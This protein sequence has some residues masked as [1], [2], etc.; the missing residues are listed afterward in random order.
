MSVLVRVP[1]DF[2][3]V[4]LPEEL[5]IPLAVATDLI[6]PS[7]GSS[8]GPNTSGPSL[9]SS[10]PSDSGAPGSQ[11]T[12]ISVPENSVKSTSASP[13]VSIP[14]TPGSTAASSTDRGLGLFGFLYSFPHPWARLST[15]IADTK[16]AG[17]SITG[18][19]PSTS[20]SGSESTEGP[21][22]LTV[23]PN[24]NSPDGLKPSQTSS[25][26]TW[27]Q[28]VV[29][30]MNQKTFSLST[31]IIVALIAFLTGSLLRSLLSPADFVFFGQQSPDIL[32]A[33]T[34]HGDR[35]ADPNAVHFQAG[36]WRELRRLVELKRIFGGW[37]LQLAAVRRH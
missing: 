27:P 37:D 13:V 18:P 5:R 17:Q 4:P 33:E 30:T 20:S 25:S 28:N 29:T 1:A 26:S 14:P 12:D 2:D 7:A 11:P 10:T 24:S 15:S 22:D 23:E 16:I 8:T 3:S 36:A 9:D 31:L 19:A 32:A 34:L 6:D 35:A 21:K